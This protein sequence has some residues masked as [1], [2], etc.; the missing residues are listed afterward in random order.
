MAYSEPRP[1][2][3]RV[4]IRVWC[5]CGKQVGEYWDEIREKYPFWC[6]DCDETCNGKYPWRLDTRVVAQPG[7][8]QDT[9][10]GLVWVA[11]A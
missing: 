6:E 3:Y 7:R 4:L 1:D 9:T 2:G 5:A 11:D 8:W 10:S